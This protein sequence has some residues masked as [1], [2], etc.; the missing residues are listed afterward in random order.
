MTQ[1]NFLLT[2]SVKPVTDHSSDEDKADK[3]RKKIAR[4]TEW[5]KTSDVETTF[6]G[7]VE[8]TKI[9][10]NYKIDQ[11]REE[12][13]RVFIPILETY[14]AGPLDVQIH[15]AMMVENIDQPFEFVVHQ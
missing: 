5:M 9:S 10:E 1:R 13:E 11:A 7:K 12:I 3:V 2:Y 14:N 6:L 8:I 15:C 4:I